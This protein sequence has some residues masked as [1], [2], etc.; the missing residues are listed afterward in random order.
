MKLNLNTSISN[1]IEQFILQW[2]VKELIGWRHYE[3]N[4]KGVYH[5]NTLFY[6]FGWT[7]DFHRRNLKIVSSFWHL[8]QLC[9]MIGPDS[10]CYF[11]GRRIKW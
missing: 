1:T 2:G 6:F 8:G 9:F 11:Y 4:V 7:V 5:T 10:W 3:W